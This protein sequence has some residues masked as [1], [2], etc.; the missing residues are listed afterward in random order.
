M[1]AALE[2]AP[3]IQKRWNEN[4][5]R[6]QLVKSAFAAMQAGEYQECAD[7]VGSLVEKAGS[8]LEKAYDPAQ[9]RDHKGRWTTPGGQPA[10]LASAVSDV[11]GRISGVSRE[12]EG[13]LASIHH[14]RSGSPDTVQ[15]VVALGR[16]LHGLAQE[17]RELPHEAVHL[18]HQARAS[19]L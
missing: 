10:K 2:A 4:A 8:N 6:S 11:A 12:L 19:L 5:Q 7:K 17:L 14:L 16:S 1:A 13:A 3:E 18:G 15:H 9:L